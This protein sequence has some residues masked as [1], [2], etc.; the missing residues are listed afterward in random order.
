M[1]LLDVFPSLLRGGP[2]QPLPRLRL[3]V[4][5][6]GYAPGQAFDPGGQGAIHPELESDAEIAVVARTER[7]QPRLRCKR[8]ADLAAVA[9]RVVDHVD[10]LDVGDVFSCNS[11]FFGVMRRRH[12]LTEHVADGRLTHAGSPR[13]LGLSHPSFGEPLDEA[14]PLLLRDAIWIERRGLLEAP[15][16]AV[17]GCLN[18]PALLPHRGDKEPV[19]VFHAER[20]TRRDAPMDTERGERFGNAGDRRRGLT[21]RRRLR[22]RYL[23]SYRLQDKRR[24]QSGQGNVGVAGCSPPHEPGGADGGLARHPSDD[25][26]TLL[27]ARGPVG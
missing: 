15:V 17:A 5:L 13:D 10:V 4:V 23:R 2:S 22:H 8:P 20:V 21:F 25:A 7:L 24:F 12:L 11:R 19:R 1:R 14:I 3:P 9:V 26:V 6:D 27:Q 16:D 18:G